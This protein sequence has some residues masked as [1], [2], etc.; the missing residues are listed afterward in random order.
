M[1]YAHVVA[2]VCRKPWAILPEKLVEIAE[3]IRLSASGVKL[4]E[5]E[6]LA[7]M[8]A[9]PRVSPKGAGAVAVIPIM[10]T[11]TRRANLM[12]NF[13][14]G[15]SIE[16]L[17]A[18]FRQALAD[19]SVKAIVFNV[20]SP[21]GNVDGVP[22]LAAEI[23]ASR[24]KK[25]TIAVADTMAASAAYWLAASASEIVVPPSGAVGSI[26]VFAVHKDLSQALDA[27]GMK[28]TLVSAGK[29]KTEGNPYEPL[30]P[31]A[32]AAIQSDVDQFYSMFVKAVSKG[33][34]VTQ[35]A[36]RGGFGEGR[37][38]MAGD[39]VKEGMADRVATMDEVLSGLGVGSGTG[40]AKL[41][42]AAEFP[43]RALRER[44][45]TLYK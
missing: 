38:V 32:R 26:G 36:V 6:I 20:D 27:A 16:Q 39:A 14:G 5:E 19:P 37:M 4:S 12:S 41:A 31:E 13:S 10:G 28:V 11:I 22:E 33:R 25:K 3:F 2:E 43:M 34:G 9:G 17:T 45:L 18:S 40:S 7:S 15:T 42:E 8:S 21:G 44:E 24:D 1:K 30:S 29:F 23:L 35:E